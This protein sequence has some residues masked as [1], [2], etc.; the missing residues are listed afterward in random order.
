M[1]TARRG[2]QGSG[3]L[4]KLTLVLLSEKLPGATLFM[5]MAMFALQGTAAEEDPDD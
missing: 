3:L 1:L 2:F 4:S 5:K